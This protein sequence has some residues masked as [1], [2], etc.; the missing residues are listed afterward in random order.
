[1]RICLNQTMVRRLHLRFAVLA[2]VAALACAQCVHAQWWGGKRH[3]QAPEP[4]KAGKVAGNTFTFCT[5]RYESVRSEALG[6]GWSTDWPD[7]GYNFM[8][9]LAELTTIKVNLDKSGE[10][11][12]TVVTLTDKALFD[13]PYAFMSDVGTAAFSK[14]EA[15][16]LRAYLL[17]G[18]FLHV[19]DFWGTPAWENWAY[20]IGQVLPPD[21]YP[22]R[23]IP[24]DD[25][26]FH[27]VFNVKEVPQVPS[28]QYWRGTRDG[29]TSERG[30]DSAIP[31]FRGIRDK[32]GRLMVVMTHNTDLAD[33]WEKEREE[34]EYF[35]EFS[36]KKSYPLGI[37]IVVYALTH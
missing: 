5:I 37:N 30:V 27:I 6:F 26:I 15:D 28:I 13:Y 19:D 36:V 14:E 1:M 32:T 2:F 31:H 21:E 9:R 7:S 4:P 12:Q 34:E 25:D 22:I 24:L 33:G 17:R 10:P 16:N 18:G 35:R 20:E 29:T 23:D 3:R 11:V 8:L